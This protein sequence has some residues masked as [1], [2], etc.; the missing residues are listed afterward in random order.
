MAKTGSISFTQGQQSGNSTYIEVRGIITT[1]GE[2]YRGSHRTGTYSIAQDGVQISSG[3]F[4]SAAPAN[5]TTEL[6]VVGLW[7]NHKSD[8]SSGTISASYN[9]DSGWCTG[10]GSTT[11]SSIVFW[12][13]INAYSPSGVQDF[14]SAIFNVSYSDG[15]AYYDMKNEPEPALYKPYGTVMSVSNIHPYYDY[16][17]ITS[18]TGA[19]HIGNGVYQKTVT[20]G[21]IIEIRTA[22]QE[23][24]LTITPNG[25]YR[26]EDNNTD[27]ITVTKTYG[28][29]EEIG[30]RRRNNYTLVGY[31]VANS[32]NGSTV[33]LGGATFS[34]D[35]NTKIGTF[36]Q[37]SVPCTL[38]PQ[39]TPNTYT[40]TFNGNG[41]TIAI[42]S[43]K[44]AYE[45]EQNNDVSRYIPSRQAYEF[46]GWY[47]SPVGGI[48]VYDANG[49]CTNDG[50]YWLNDV[51]VYTEDY[52]LYAQWKALNLAYYKLNGEWL[53]CYS[54]IKVNGIWYAAIYK[55]NFN[56]DYDFEIAVLLDEEGNTL[57][58]ENGNVL[59]II[60]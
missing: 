37:G 16:Y 4:Q 45:T 39:W 25:G 13:D 17:K 30:E 21:S 22:Y 6:F 57:T 3:S 56:G 11:L 53:R 41:G 5:S 47:T 19:T 31:T 40:I 36:K 2:S 26:V 20:D 52:T 42:S 27:V 7:V 43:L 18:I 8:G 35:N 48:Q 24:L 15:S 33:D 54:Y 10:N 44:I 1:S 49:L 34:F 59:V 12:N 46:L 9:Y 14:K 29:T 28:A 51:C 32:S 50:T 38:I 58:D 23:Y 60:E 55:R